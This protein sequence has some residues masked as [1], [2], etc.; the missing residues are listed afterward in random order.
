[1]TQE[2]LPQP[3]PDVQA[4]PIFASTDIDADAAIVYNYHRMGMPLRHC[5]AIFTLCSLDL[6]V[7]AHAAQLY[8]DGYADLLIF[9]GGSSAMTAGRFPGFASEAA[10]F[11]A[12]ARDMGVPDSALLLE[13]RSTNTGE[14][15]RFTHALLLASRGGASRMPRSFLLVQKP[16]MERRTWATFAKQW[17]DGGEG[18]GGATFRVTSPPLEWNAYPD[19]KNPRDL[20]LNLMVGDLVRIRDYPIRGF[21]VAQEIPSEVWVASERLIA[22]GYDAHL[23]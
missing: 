18:D 9:S 3:N 6:R 23:P 10:A 8:L 20:V 22:A 17:P 19:A 2:S 16:Y 15:V 7:A 12:V 1:M 21:Q 4:N 11:A 14:N 5:D 13:E